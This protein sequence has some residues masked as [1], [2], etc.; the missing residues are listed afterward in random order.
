MTGNGPAQ[1]PLPE[2]GRSPD[3][4]QAEGWR[5]DAEAR[6]GRTARTAAQ[7]GVRGNG[8]GAVRSEMS[9]S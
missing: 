2:L 4:G 5:T 6:W 8:R 3:A 9:E 7:T 1:L